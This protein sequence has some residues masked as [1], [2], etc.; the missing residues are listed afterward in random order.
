VD[1]F[2]LW[3]GEDPDACGAEPKLLGVYSTEDRARQRIE[4]ARSLAGFRDYPDSF[5]VARYEVDRD[6]W[7]E[8]Y[9]E[10]D[11]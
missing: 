11:V 8:G 4:S 6:E 10:I 9:A 2:L 3:R 7:S 5:Q 1:E